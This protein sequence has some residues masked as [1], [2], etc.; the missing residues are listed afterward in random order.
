MKRSILS[1][2]AVIMLSSCKSSF[3]VYHAA[4]ASTGIVQEDNA[5]VYDNGTIRVVY[6]FWAR[7]GVMSYV[8]YN[9]SKKPIYIDWKRSSFIQDKE[10][11][12]YYIDAS[13]S[14]FTAV[15]AGHHSG[16]ASGSVSV[17]A[18]SEVRAERVSFLP[19]GSFIEKK[20]YKLIPG[21]LLIPKDMMSDTL[22]G[23][24][25]AKIAHLEKND[26]TLVFRNFITYSTTE[27]FKEE[28]Y[29]DNEFYIDNVLTAHN[30]TVQHDK[31][32][33]YHYPGEGPQNFYM[34]NLTPQQIY[35]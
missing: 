30:G 10:K 17:G 32:G 6:D 24:K 26:G 5:Y 20:F 8:V 29:V 15:S 16:S 28:Q 12:N 35:K 18:G 11:K 7:Q 31:D 4:P 1:L 22:I 13:T 19:P 9:T 33:H 14:S 21:N 2:A 34:N 25:A 3:Q 27:E 23:R